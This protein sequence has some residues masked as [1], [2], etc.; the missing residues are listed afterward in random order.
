MDKSTQYRLDAEYVRMSQ[1][2]KSQMAA[3]QEAL[4]EASKPKY[5]PKDHKRLMILSEQYAWRHICK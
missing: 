4:R 5:P 3:L 1:R 2:P